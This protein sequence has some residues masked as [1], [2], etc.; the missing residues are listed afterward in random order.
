MIYF[1]ITNDIGKIVAGN[2]HNFLLAKKYRGSKN[3][4][5]HKKDVGYKGASETTN[6]GIGVWV[7][8]ENEK[9]LLRSSK[10][11]R[12]TF[13]LY[14]E[15]AFG[16]C[17]A[18]KEQ[19]LGTRHILPNIH[20]QM[21]QSFDLFARNDVGIFHG[22]TLNTLVE[23]V[24]KQIQNNTADAAH[25]IIYLNKL[26]LDMGAHL[27]G[28]DVIH[29]GA[30]Y[31]PIMKDVRV[32]AAILHQYASFTKEFEE[33]FIQLR[34]NAID[35]EAIVTVDKDMFS[36]IMYN[37]LS[38]AVKYCKPHS[39]VRFHFSDESKELDV[40]MI[41]LRI[42]QDEIQNIF[43]EGIRGRHATK[44]PGS[45]IGLFVV[46]TALNKMGK[47]PLRIN[48]NYQEATELNGE[49]YVE[50]HFHFNFS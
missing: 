23:R 5:E 29:F 38:N 26:V 1:E 30:D 16:I 49:Q 19:L 13:N 18:Q 17:R 28:I 6:D 32:R 31:K 21:V 15:V 24:S 27:R 12:Q 34:V 40:S 7:V 4:S 35:D 37:M 9:D 39:E 2:M 47:Q 42:E 50:N 8:A 3:F 41:S 20:T 11:F 22:G 43:N 33:A 48:P 44:T 10:L 46:K 25:L 45:G 36:L 14:K